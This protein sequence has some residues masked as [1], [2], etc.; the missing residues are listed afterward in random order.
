MGKQFRYPRVSYLK[1]QK[2]FVLKEIFKENLL[3]I[4]LL[5]EF[6][7]ES[8]QKSVPIIYLLIFSNTNSLI[9]N[10]ILMWYLKDYSNGYKF[11]LYQF[12]CNIR[13][14]RTLNGY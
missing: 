11:V 3:L 12:V 2:I 9:Y 1:S 10:K 13:V 14:N 7:R 6:S 4:N 5:K 8:A